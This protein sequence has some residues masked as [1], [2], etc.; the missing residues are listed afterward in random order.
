MFH[1]PR[2]SMHH[3]LP[4][5]ESPPRLRS[6]ARKSAERLRHHVWQGDT[7]PLSSVREH[8][9]FISYPWSNIVTFPSLS[10]PLTGSSFSQYTGIWRTELHR[11]NR[12]YEG[13]CID[14]DS[15]P[16]QLYRAR[17]TPPSGELH[18]RESVNQASL[19]VPPSPPSI[20]AEDARQGHLGQVGHVLHRC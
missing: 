6:H 15:S 19:S 2:P 11:D 8:K 13:R 1:V 20:I 18:L 4:N 12:A 7:T 14:S 5:V 16:S 9:H 17:G 3:E 10:V